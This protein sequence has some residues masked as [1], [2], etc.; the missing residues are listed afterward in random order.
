[1]PNLKN[2]GGYPDNPAPMGIQVPATATITESRLNS[3][4]V[5]LEGPFY[6]LR[7]I[8]TN[9]RYVVDTTRPGID[10]HRIDFLVLN[11]LEEFELIDE[12]PVPTE[13]RVDFHSK[14]LT[15]GVDK[16]CS[17]M[18]ERRHASL[19]TIPPRN[20]HEANIQIWPHA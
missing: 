4:P 19:A 7:M 18:D 10:I 11:I 17:R 2:L 6:H 15:L 3:A 5:M 20:L 13:A 9:C 1:M 8:E 14:P 16:M 12:S